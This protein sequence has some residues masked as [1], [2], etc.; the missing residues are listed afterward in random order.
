MAFWGD[1]IYIGIGEHYQLGILSMTDLDYKEIQK[2]YYMPNGEEI[3]GSTQGVVIN[4][5]YLWIFLNIGG[6]RDNYLIQYR[7]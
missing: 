1:T 2:H 3:I 6:M 7:R 4:S 5:K